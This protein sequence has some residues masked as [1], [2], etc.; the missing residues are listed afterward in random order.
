MSTMGTLVGTA[1]LQCSGLRGLAV[2]AVGV[3]VGGASSPSLG[4]ELP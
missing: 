1:G 4:Q 2:A 3:L